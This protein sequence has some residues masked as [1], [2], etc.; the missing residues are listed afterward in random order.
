MASTF[1]VNKSAHIDRLVDGQD[2]HAEYGAYEIGH[3]HIRS[4]EDVSTTTQMVM[5]LLPDALRGHI[6][7]HVYRAQ[8]RC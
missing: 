5:M 4:N 6:I 3:P 8:S 1:D 2:R 7:K